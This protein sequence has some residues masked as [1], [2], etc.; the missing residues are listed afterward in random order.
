MLV[1]M[2]C[3]RGAYMLGYH[4]NMLR[5]WGVLKHHIIVTQ[6]QSPTEAEPA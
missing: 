1:V 5:R 4:A 6:I 2:R 3:N